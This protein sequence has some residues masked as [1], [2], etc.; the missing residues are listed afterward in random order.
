[1]LHVI[2]LNFFPQFLR[3]VPTTTKVTKPRSYVSVVVHQSDTE[4]NRLV[5]ENV[6]HFTKFEVGG[7]YS[8]FNFSFTGIVLLKI[9]L[10][11]KVFKHF[12]VF[13]FS[14]FRDTIDLG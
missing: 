14:F 2:G 4:C 11:S 7:I 13:I 3:D 10:N 5:T 12:D 6:A 1:M 9:K 8:V